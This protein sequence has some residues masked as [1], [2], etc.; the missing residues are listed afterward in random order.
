MINQETMPARVTRVL[1]L[2]VWLIITV[3]PLYWI[4]V[5][6]FKAPGPIFSYPLTYWPEVFSIE[7]YVGLFEKAQF[8]TYI[9]NSLLISTVAAIFATVISMLSAYVLARFDFRTKGALLMA[10]LVTQ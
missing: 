9:V 1:F 10:F 2:G 8:G 4:V 5:T 7:N 3:F 6:S